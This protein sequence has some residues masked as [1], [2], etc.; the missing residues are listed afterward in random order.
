MRIPLAPAGRREMFLITLLFG[1]I[2]ALAAVLASQGYV[3]LWLVAFIFGLAWIGG[4]L[5]FRDPERQS[6]QEPGILVAPADGRVTEITRLDHHE[7]IGGPAVRIGIFLSVFNVHINRV[8]CDGTVR[9]VR[10]RPGKFLDARHPESGIVNEANTVVF[11]TP[12]GPIVVRQ[13]VGLIARRIVCDLKPGDRVT[14]GQR[15]GLI[16]FGSRTELIVPEGRYEPAV[17]VGDVTVGAVTIMARLVASSDTS[18]AAQT[19][20][21]GRV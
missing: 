14:L 12:Q 11:D 10:Y 17:R 19:V 7:D 21:A 18:A 6:P 8:P 1:G 13:V 3:Y 2:A 5:F 15:M 20:E 16:K 4:L 9:D